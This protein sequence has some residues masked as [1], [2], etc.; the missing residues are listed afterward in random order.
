MNN[1]FAIRRFVLLCP[2]LLQ[3]AAPRETQAQLAGTFRSAPGTLATYQYQANG[4][5]SVLLPADVTIRFSDNNPTSMLTAIIHKPIIGDTAG[6][7]N[8]P[9]VNEFPMVVTGTSSDGRTFTG[10]L[11]DTQYMFEWTFESA[12]GGGLT[13]DGQVGWAGG[14]FELSTIADAQLI[15][16]VPG[17]YNRNGAVDAA[18]FVVWRK[19]FGQSGIGL[20][21]NGNGD[22]RVDADD[23]NIWRAHFG[24][25]S[26]G[27]L[28]AAGVPE[29]ATWLI[30]FV[31]LLAG[32][33]FHAARGRIRA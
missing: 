17:D 18:D 6:S 7:H 26:P 31:A 23:Y 8:F 21:A 15:P 16:V 19:T 2:F 28:A 22:S 1:T 11:L 25:A 5:E 13:W 14:R 10:D 27:S 32:P 30:L 3:V 33:I 9:I 4:F 29:P 24:A 12:P 20:I